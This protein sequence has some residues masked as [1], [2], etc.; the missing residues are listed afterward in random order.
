MS[1][2]AISYVAQSQSRAVHNRHG[3]GLSRVV[4]TMTMVVDYPSER[5]RTVCGVFTERSNILDGKFPK[6][7]RLC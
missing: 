7:D 2:S 6:D 1:R 4:D 3:G 5:M